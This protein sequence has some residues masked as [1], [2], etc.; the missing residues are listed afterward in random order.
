MNRPAENHPKPQIGIY[1]RVGTELV[2]K[3][4]PLD[5]VTSHNGFR[6]SDD[7]HHSYWERWTAMQRVDLISHSY[8]HFPR[9]RIVY[10][11]V[12]EKFIIYGDRCLI[13]NKRFIHRLQQMFGLPASQCEVLNDAHYQCH[14]C[15]PDFISDLDLFE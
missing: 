13:G 14:R 9:G 15:N 3:G 1:W 12:D 11:E 4:V 2:F 6:D 8:D 7:N 10:R 5:R